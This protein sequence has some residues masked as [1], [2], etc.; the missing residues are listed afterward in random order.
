M[1]TTQEQAVITSAISIIETKLRSTG[2][3]ITTSEAACAYLRLN[4]A[5]LEHEVFA[6][7]LLDTQH[8][9]INFVELFR[10]TI[11]SAAVYPRE[12]VKT[13]LEENAAAV[14]FTHNHPSNIAEPSEADKV[15]TRRL[16][17]A[18][19]TIEVRVLDHI[20]V[21]KSGSVSFA[22]RGLL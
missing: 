8:R 10:G 20:V 3:E 13:V 21:T 12:V 2:V 11:D 14:I 16:A 5:H 22:D 7:M 19:N 15:I 4:I 17:A 1:F 18:L 6:I 9:L